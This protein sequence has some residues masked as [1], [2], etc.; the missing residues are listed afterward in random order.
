[1]VDIG[2]ISYTDRPLIKR[3]IKARSIEF[4]KL[5]NQW[6]EQR[7]EGLEALGSAGPGAGSTATAA[8]LRR[9]RIANL[10]TGVDTRNDTFKEARQ[11]IREDYSRRDYPIKA[12]ESFLLEGDDGKDEDGHGTLTTTLLLKAAPWADLYV[13]KIASGKTTG[14]CDAIAEVGHP[15]DTQPSSQSLTFL[16]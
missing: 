1:V 6:T 14:E 2:L 4:F 9:I 3:I 15:S 11:R 13:A 16:L 5:L 7:L 10:D 12:V 8:Q